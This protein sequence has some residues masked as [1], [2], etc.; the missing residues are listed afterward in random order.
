M[1]QKINL[2]KKYKID[3]KTKDELDK[4]IYNLI[5]LVNKTYL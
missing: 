5:E 3:D 1:R 4:I 2:Y